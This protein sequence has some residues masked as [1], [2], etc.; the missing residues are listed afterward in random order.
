M[1]RLSKKA[2]Y[3]I[4]ALSHLHATQKPTSA[5]AIASSY[6]LSA[7]MLANVLKSLTSAGIL[8]SKRGVAGGYILGKD[9]GNITVGEVIDVIDGPSSFS[10]CTDISKTCRAD[11]LCPAKKPVILIH[12]RIKYFMDSISLQ[13]IVSDDAFPELSFTFNNR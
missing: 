5:K 13:D 12:K 1:F 10:D 6:D 11:R 8:E 7:Q 4:V 2:D 3:A 9:P